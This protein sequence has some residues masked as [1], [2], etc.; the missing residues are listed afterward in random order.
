[1]KKLKLEKNADRSRNFEFENRKNTKNQLAIFFKI[2]FWISKI[3]IGIINN[4]NLQ[5]QKNTGIKAYELL[6]SKKIRG[7]NN[8]NKQYKRIWIQ[9]DFFRENKSSLIRKNRKTTQYTKDTKN[10]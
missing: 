7:Y 5:T 6:I 2:Y 3:N 8:K 10:T 9:A 4:L 1:M